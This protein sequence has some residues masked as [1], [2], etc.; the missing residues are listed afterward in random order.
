MLADYVMKRIDN[1]FSDRLNCKEIPKKTKEGT[2]FD[3]EVIRK[4]LHKVIR[5]DLPI[6][7]STFIKNT[8]PA[9]PVSKSKL[10]I[11]L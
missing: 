7:G 11:L 4:S 1:L 8:E 9:S 3:K 2:T 6:E 10:K 5:K